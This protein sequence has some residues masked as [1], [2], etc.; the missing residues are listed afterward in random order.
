ML[1]RPNH[2]DRQTANYTHTSSNHESL[3]KTDASLLSLS[4]SLARST[5]SVDA[6]ERGVS[7][8]DLYSNQW[9]HFFPS[10]SHT[11]RL[12]SSQD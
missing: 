9:C 11:D 4:G 12:I 1:C 7:R 2:H 6:S 10:E 8:R 5:A 3:K